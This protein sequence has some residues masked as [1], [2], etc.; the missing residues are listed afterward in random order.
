[1]DYVKLGN[2]GLDVSQIWLG[3]MNF[4]STAGG[5][6]NEWTPCRM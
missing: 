1:M 3:R 2:T 4:G 5:E 6:H